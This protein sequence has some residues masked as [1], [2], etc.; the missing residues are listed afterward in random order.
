ME[1]NGLNLYSRQKN[2]RGVNCVV[3]RVQPGLSDLSET[4][5]IPSIRKKD[6]LHLLTRM[7]RLTVSVGRLPE[8]L[9]TG[10]QYLI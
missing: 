5:N 2:N 10:I 7:S 4:I 9:W 3:P 1:V 8:P 6:V